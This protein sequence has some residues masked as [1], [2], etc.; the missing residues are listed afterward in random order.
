MKIPFLDLRAQ[1]VVIKGEIKRSLKEVMDTTAFA[2]GPFVQK[3]E[4]QFSEFCGA[5]YCVAVNSGTSALHLA[6][7]SHGINSGDEVITVPNTFIATAWAITYCNAKPVFVDVDSNTWLMNPD[8]IEQ[9]IT[10]KTKAIL[11]VH[12]YGQPVDLDQINKIAKKNNLIV[13]E[14][15][16]QAHAATYKQNRIG[17][18][19]N[20]TCFSFYPGKNLGAC[21]EG[22]AVVTDDKDIANHIRMLRDHGQSKKYHHDFIGYNYRMDGFQGSILS[23]KL[24]YLQDWTQKRNKIAHLYNNGLLDIKNLQVPYVRNYVTSAFHLYVIHTEHRDDLLNYLNNNGISSGLHYPIPIHLQPAAASL[25]YS[26]GD[27]VVCE[28]Q[29]RRILSIPIHQY[30]VEKDVQ[31][32]ADAVNNFYSR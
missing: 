23:V 15:A 28:A 20:T 22:G 16:A 17:G 1:H 7:L 24:K 21:G 10:P 26:I 19:G 9:A 13:I 5:K 29:A 8:L 25:G 27:F 12:L 11:P 18:L 2:S 3:F 14:D 32:V 4:E 30:L 6:L 31:F